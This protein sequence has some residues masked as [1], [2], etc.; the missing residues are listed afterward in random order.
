MFKNKNMQLLQNMLQGN[1]MNNNIF[2]FTRQFAVLFFLTGFLFVSCGGPLQEKELRNN[3]PEGALE[4]KSGKKYKGTFYAQEKPDVDFYFVAINYPT[5][6]KGELSGI[7]GVDSSIAFYR[8]IEQQPFKVIN[9]GQSS[10]GEQFGPIRIESPGVW[11]ALR[12]QHLHSQAEYKNLTYTFS[13]TLFSPPS[14]MESEGNDSP[15]L[16]EAFPANSDGVVL[17]YYNNVFFS[18]NELERDYFLYKISEEGKMLVNF[19]LSAVAGIDPILRVYDADGVLLMTADD[20][21]IGKGES[22]RSL[23]VQGPTQLTVCVN[24]KDFLTNFSEYYQLKATHKPYES[25]FE[26]EPN[27][28]IETASPILEERTFGQLSDAFDKDF[29]VL[30]N[31]LRQA[32]FA[33]VDI[34]PAAALDIQIEAT[35][36]DGEIIKFDDAGREGTEG[37]SNILL[38]NEQELFFSLQKKDDNTKTQETNPFSYTIVSR[39]IPVSDNM[40][41]ENNNKV[42]EANLLNLDSEYMG[43]INPNTDVDFWRVNSSSLLQARLLIGGVEGCKIKAS[44]ADADGI[45]LSSYISQKQGEGLSQNTDFPPNA[46]VKVECNEADKNLYRHPYTIAISK[47]Q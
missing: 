31:S 23:A 40:E 17:G 3:T 44:V 16:A 14:F 4:I 27:D 1:I 21:G 20:K 30:K 13:V 29:F 35:L 10:L 2:F 6:I 9:D 26:A 24:A 12:S 15:A 18:E 33:N 36:P 5:M 38:E 19:A 41:I 42:S 46:I 25:R 8:S 7:K 39:F 37:L 32:V 43:Y 34:L 28:S 45:I 11:I 22:I 47:N